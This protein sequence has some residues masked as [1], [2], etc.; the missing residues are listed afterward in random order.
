MDY[1]RSYFDQ[2]VLVVLHKGKEAGTLR[3]TLPSD[4]VGKSISSMNGFQ[5]S[6]QGN[7]VEIA[8]P[9][10]GHDYLEVR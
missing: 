9:A 7:Q 10:D 4:L 1:L 2:N 8:L 6:A 3:F 5:V